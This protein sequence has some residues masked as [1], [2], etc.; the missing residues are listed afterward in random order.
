M[1][2]LETPAAL[3]TITFHSAFF[4]YI[5][6]FPNDH[7]ID[8]FSSFLFL[9]ISIFPNDHEI[10]VFNSFSFVNISAFLNAHEIYYVFRTNSPRI[11]H[12]VIQINRIV[13]NMRCITHCFDNHLDIEL[14]NQNLN[15]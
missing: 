5:S 1:L 8:V 10:D 3:Y 12:V 9:N 15:A 7:E 4:E 14:W 11:G 2:Q 6:V 13:L